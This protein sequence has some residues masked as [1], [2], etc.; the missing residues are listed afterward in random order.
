V[1]VT[2]LDISQHDS[3]RWPYFLPDGKHFLY[4]ASSHED[5]S[6]AHDGIYV[7]SL[8]GKENKVVLRAHSNVA[9]ANGHLLYV[10]DS[11]LM[12]QPF[13]LR[14]LE[15]TGEASP[16]AENVETDSGWWLSIFTV[17]QN[18]ALAFSPINP[19]SGNKLLWFDRSGMQV[20]SVADVGRYRTLQLSPDGQQLAVEI[21]QPNSDLWVYELKQNSRSQLTLG[22]SGNTLPAWSP[23]GRQIVFSSDRKNG[24]TDIYKK[25]LSG[26][27][28]EQVLLQSPFNK[29]VMDWSPDGRLLL[30][31]ES[32]GHYKAS[33]K[34][35][36]LDGQS[37]PRLLL[38]AP[39]YE[40]DGRFSPDGRWIADTSRQQG[41][42][43]VFAIPFP[44]PGAVKQI[45]ATGGTV[46]PIWRKDGKAIFYLD[47]NDNLMETEVVSDGDSLTVGKTR[48]LF[49][50]KAYTFVYQGFPYD[51]SRD[52]QRFLINTRAEEDRAEVTV[53]TN[54]TADLKK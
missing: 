26:P 12:A 53:I 10:R 19:N 5:V 46:S 47:D 22:S 45:S 15:L 8:D 20:G 24:I 33:L 48:Q 43:F 1:A 49:K 34:V 54:W 21:E 30:Y 6:H 2:K 11:T 27:Q 41:P 9:Y 3:H 38:E 29:Y 52:G 23:D 42:L 37:E 7:A 13:D 50:T 32:N 18:G 4:F 36:P 44:G 25:S 17:S 14:R 35:L 31:L 40:Q 39:F 28:G 16:A 51:V